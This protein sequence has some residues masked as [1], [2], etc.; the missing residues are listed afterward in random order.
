M[1]A[2]HRELDVSH[3]IVEPP[4]RADVV[5]VFLD[6]LRAAKFEPRPASG[7]FRRHAGGNVIRDL[8]IDV[9]LQL[10]IDLAELADDVHQILKGARPGVI[11]IYQPTKFQLLVNLKTAKALALTLPP[12]LIA[13]ADEVIE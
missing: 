10:T 4:H 13:R 11:P 1:I 12:G 2:T 9:E 6:L 8:A 7:F 3:P 5:D